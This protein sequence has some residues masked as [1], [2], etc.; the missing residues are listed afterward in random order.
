MRWIAIAT[1][2]REPSLREELKIGSPLEGEEL[3]IEVD[4]ADQDNDG[5]DDLAARFVLQGSASASIRF[6]FATSTLR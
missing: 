2:G 4:A 6:R 3:R 1:P 5:R